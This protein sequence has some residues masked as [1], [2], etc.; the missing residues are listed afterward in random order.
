MHLWLL[1]E[2][3]AL[4]LWVG[5]MWATGYLVAP[6]LFRML[7]DRAQAGAIA[8]QLFAISNWIGL[9]CIALLL[10]G[11]LARNGRAWFSDW[12][13]WVLLAALALVLI[14]EFALAPAMRELK[15]AAGGDLVAHAG[16]HRRFATL[17]GVSSTLFVVTSLLGLLLA[18]FG[19]TR[20]NASNA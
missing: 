15:A 12:R 2:R 1:S 14:A 13:A 16:L 18:L 4:T 5:G 10:L 9:A 20:T 3:A 6:V 11:A 7:D 17:H 8:G 19:V